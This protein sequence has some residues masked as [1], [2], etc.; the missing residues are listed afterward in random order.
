MFKNSGIT[1][2]ILRL[3]T[4]VF[5]TECFLLRGFVLNQLLGIFDPAEQLFQRRFCGD[6]LEMLYDVGEIRTL[7]LVECV[8]KRERH[9]VCEGEIGECDPVT[10]DAGPVFQVFVDRCQDIPLFCGEYFA[11]LECVIVR[12]KSYILN[13]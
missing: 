1:S 13:D 6:Q 10:N 11:Q 2:G 12:R 5:P 3:P 4:W 9:R 8:R 7:L